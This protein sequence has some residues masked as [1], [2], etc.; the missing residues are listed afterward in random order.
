[1]NLMH[2]LH[3]ELQI[4]FR[5]S[6]VAKRF[7]IIVKEG[8]EIKIV[9]FVKGRPSNILTRLA[10]WQI[11]HQLV[12]LFFAK[13]VDNLLLQVNLRRN[14]QDL[15][16]IR[17][18]PQLF[19]SQFCSI[20]LHFQVSALVPHILGVRKD[21]SVFHSNPPPPAPAPIQP[22]L[23]WMCVPSLIGAITP[24]PTDRCVPRTCEYIASHFMSQ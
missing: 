19:S 21:G 23:R 22:E 3:W 10:F 7:G 8:R 4:G 12:L 14:I 13:T 20:L 1:M 18:V 5:F 6:I 11:Y 15:M 2:S 17:I 9:Y 16:P 24:L